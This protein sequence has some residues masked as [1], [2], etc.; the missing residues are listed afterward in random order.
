MG[1]TNIQTTKTCARI[2]CLFF[3]K[4]I[5]HFFMGSGPSTAQNEYRQS[6]LPY[7]NNYLTMKSHQSLS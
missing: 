5:D 7:A 4:D 3:L 1:K 6:T 2:K